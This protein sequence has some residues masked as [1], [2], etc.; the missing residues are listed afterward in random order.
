MND[1]FHLKVPFHE[2]CK[3]ARFYG[4]RE[5]PLLVAVCVHNK[6]QRERNKNQV[7]NFI[8]ATKDRYAKPKEKTPE[9]LAEEKRQEEKKQ[10]A[11]ERAN[12]FLRRRNQQKKEQ[13]EAAAK[14]EAVKAEEE[15]KEQKPPEEE[16]K[17]EN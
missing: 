2:E 11:N 6:M 7:V 13:E 4:V 16:K 12:A 9:E 1:V 17:A 15:K 3:I 14:A 8:R 10:K 5:A